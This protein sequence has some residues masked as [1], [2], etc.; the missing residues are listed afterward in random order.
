VTTNVQ[1]A[2]DRVDG[3]VFAIVSDMTTSDS[4]FKQRTFHDLAF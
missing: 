2:V 1:A 3:C 4:G